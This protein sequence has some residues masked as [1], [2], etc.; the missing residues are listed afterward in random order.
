MRTKEQILKMLHD[1][2][3][4]KNREIGKI[5]KEIKRLNARKL[6]L[7]RQISN[8][9]LYRNRLLNLTKTD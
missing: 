8:N 3:N 9:M 4:E 5:D 1:S 7:A 2:E 6:K